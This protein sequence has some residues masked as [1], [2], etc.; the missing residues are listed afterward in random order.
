MQ[1]HLIITNYSGHTEFCDNDNSCLIDGGETE[2]AYDGFFF[3][4]Q[5]GS[6][7]KWGKDQEEQ[8]INHLRAIYK[9]ARSPNKNDTPEKFTWENSAKKIMLAIS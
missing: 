3:K 6:W 9:S 2:A 7:L 4:S 5:V 1:K 8:A